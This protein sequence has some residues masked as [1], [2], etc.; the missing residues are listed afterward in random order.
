M[1]STIF[2]L[3][4]ALACLLA[5][6][7]MA[8]THQ[9]VCFVGDSI[10]A[11]FASPSTPWP[12][13]LATRRIGTKFSVINMGVPG[14]R[15]DQLESGL[16]PVCPGCRPFAEVIAN[17]GCT[18]IF[19][20]CGVNDVMQGLTFAQIYG[21]GDTVGTRGPWLRMVRAAQAAGIPVTV[22]T[23]APW[24]GA[25]LWTSGKQTVQDAVNAA[26]RTTSGVTLVD[27][28]VAMGEPT[29][30]Q[31]LR[32]ATAP[33]YQGSPADSLHWGVAG[34]TAAANA[35]DAVPGAL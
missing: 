16:Q 21:T 6:P 5:A 4:I 20:F 22:A 2:R 17:R 32:S 11:G 31:A 35:I 30:T 26:I 13:L 27:L 28:Y 3:G 9:L 1:K 33:S 8:Q 29:D 18:R 12:Q 19:L 25:S 15:C 7:A 24:K 14:A 10:T 34:N 23:I